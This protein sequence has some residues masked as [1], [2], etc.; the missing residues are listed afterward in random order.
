MSKDSNIRGD[1]V[2]KNNLEKSGEQVCLT[3]DSEEYALPWSTE[4]GTERLW[5][6]P[7]TGMSSL[8]SQYYSTSLCFLS[9]NWNQYLIGINTVKEM[10]V[11]K[12]ALSVA[13]MTNNNGYN[14]AYVNH[15]EIS[16]KAAFENV[17]KNVTWYNM[18]QL[19]SCVGSSVQNISLHCYVNCTGYLFA[20]RPIQN[21]GYYFKGYSFYYSR[22][23]YCLNHIFCSLMS[24]IFL[25]AFFL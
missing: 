1:E 3:H 14:V 10:E 9:E 12:I 6:N 20:S 22:P 11:V 4:F 24:A 5:F 13:Q 2:I 15:S 19:H 23:S 8:K 18:H 7:S 17:L 25:S 21:V 16:L